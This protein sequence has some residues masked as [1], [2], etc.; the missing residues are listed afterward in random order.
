MKADIAKICI[1]YKLTDSEE[2]VLRFI[3][4]NIETIENLSIR[5]VSN[6]CYCSTTV[7]MNLAKKLKYKGYSEMTQKLKEELLGKQEDLN[8][9]NSFLHTFSDFSN[10][11]KENFIKILTQHK[12]EAIYIIGSGFCEPIAKYIQ[13][14]LMLLR[15]HSFFTWHR[16]N[17]INP[18][19]E[20]PLLICISK[21]GETSYITDLAKFCKEHNYSVVSFTNDKNNTLKNFST[22]T[23]SL[24]DNAVLDE[25]NSVSNSFYPNVLF[26]FEYLIGCYLEHHKLEIPDS[27]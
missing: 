7:V 6:T 26:L 9:S 23:F 22:L 12:K 3:I 10:L 1:K 15:F 27:Y 21:S 2:D 17:Y 19:T 8:K 13:D 25:Q 16:E 20:N 24:F 14:K 4:E 11:K 5:S 18:H